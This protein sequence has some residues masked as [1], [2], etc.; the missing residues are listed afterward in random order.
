M[1]LHHQRLWFYTVN[2]EKY[3]AVIHSINHQ[4]HPISN[5]AAADVSLFFLPQFIDFASMCHI[6]VRDALHQR[7]TTSTS[8][9][10]LCAS[11]LVQNVLNC[12]HSSSSAFSVSVTQVCLNYIQQMTSYR[13]WFLITRPTEAKYLYMYIVLF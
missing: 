1:N 12:Y 11:F 4:M 13:A 2:T 9:E 10:V 6:P 5:L 7:E 8:S 3:S